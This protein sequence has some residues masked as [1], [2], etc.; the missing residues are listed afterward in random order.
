MALLL[1]NI[2]REIEGRISAGQ[3]GI[4]RRLPTEHELGKEFGVSRGTIRRSLKALCDSGVIEQ[5]RGVGCF[6]KAR[7]GAAALPV[8]A[9]APKQ[10]SFLISHVPNSDPFDL[11][12]LREIER[13]AF[14]TGATVHF[15]NIDNNPDKAAVLAR[16]WQNPAHAGVIFKPS[17]TVDY[18]RANSWILDLLERERIAY[19]VVDTP[20]ARDGVL[21][22]SFVGSDGYSAMRRLV[23]HLLEQGHRRFAS[24][25]ALKG[26]YSAD[27]R[28]RGFLDE[29]EANGIAHKPADHI[30]VADVALFRQGRREALALL[31]RGDY[32]AIVCTHDRLANN[33]IDELGRAGRRV[34][35]DIAVTGFDDMQSEAEGV[36]T[37]RQPFAQIARRTLEILFSGE[38][39]RKVQQEFLPCELVARQSSARA[40]QLV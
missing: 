7:P 38:C 2:V 13:A 28:Q 1:N 34:P 40:A 16:Q 25:Q 23:R 17:V 24:L 11:F 20:L 35:D 18:Y 27:Q 14:A 30:A 29:L 33:V 12:Y 3:Y 8:A 37:V 5:R 36:T 15:A 10:I 31:E 19:V 39:G 26:V 4:T 6:I 32:D 22:G 9:D 21:R